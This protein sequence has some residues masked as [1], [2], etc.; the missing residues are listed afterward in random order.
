MDPATGETKAKNKGKLDYTCIASGYKDLKGRLFVHKDF[1]QKVRPTVYIKEIFEH[2]DLMDYEKF[3]VETNL[4]RTLLLENIRRERKEI[5]ADRKKRGV[6]DWGI[7]VPFYEIENRDKKEKRIF[8]LEPKVNNGWILFNK[9]LSM[10][11][12]NMVEEFPGGDHDDGPDALEMLWG[13]VNNR[14]KPSPIN[15][16]AMGSR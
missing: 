10:D 9:N 2:H 3:G 14:Y 13:M 16:D 6:K 12:I 1:T 4:F 11:F 8:T 5:E 15:L 7:K